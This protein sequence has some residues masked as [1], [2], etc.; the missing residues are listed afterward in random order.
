MIIFYFCCYLFPWSSTL[1]TELVG[2]TWW[3]DYLFTDK[4]WLFGANNLVWLLLFGQFVQIRLP[5]KRDWCWHGH[6]LYLSFY[7]ANRRRG[8]CERPHETEGR[9]WESSK[10]TPDV[11]N[12]ARP[13]LGCIE[14][15]SFGAG[16]LF[17]RETFVGQD[18][19]N[20]VL[21]SFLVRNCGWFYEDNF[22]V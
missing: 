18:C 4:L 12:K 20:N 14:P 10:R 13:L 11:L 22:T 1:Y 3:T 7:A 9:L 21:L 16:V 2:R 8:C 5:R 19:Y 6:A 17:W 15:L